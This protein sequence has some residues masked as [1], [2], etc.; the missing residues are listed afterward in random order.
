MI[1]V[2]GAT[3]RVG[4]RLMEALAD[5]GAEATAMVRV[6]AR[7]ADLP[8]AGKYLVATFDSPPAPATLQAFDQVFL[9]SPAYEEQAELEMGFID[10]L[11]AAGHMPHVVKVAVDGFQEPDA[12]VR[13]ISSHRQIAVHLAA[14]GLPVTYLAPSYYMEN[15]LAA[16]ESLRLE[17]TLYASAG[18][19]RTGFVAAS[20]V[21]DV[22][23]RVLV[24]AGH[25]G[26]TYVLTGPEALSY[27]DVAERI[28]A[29]FGR[30]VE[31]A[32]L[33]AERAREQLLGGGLTPWQVEGTLELFDWIRDG[34]AGSVTDD[35]RAVTGKDA[36]PIED[37]LDE[38][39]GAFLGAPSS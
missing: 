10:A 31:Y 22:A 36:R 17:G 6:A 33:P 3:G 21:A 29:V 34:R 24:S 14:T 26:R 28:S 37:W 13:F 12:K 11:V 38:F 9:L 5:A 18:Q 15:L 1:L 7:G 30:D 4:Y 32:D 19:G 16:A 27:D 39:R 20:D 8:G 25:R 2:T 23:A 35:V